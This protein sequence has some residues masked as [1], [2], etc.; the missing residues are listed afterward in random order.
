MRPVTGIDFPVLTHCA[1]ESKE[2]AMGYDM[3]GIGGMMRKD[4]QDAERERKA[5]EKR[6]NPKPKSS[7]WGKTMRKEAYNLAND[8]DKE[9]KKLFGV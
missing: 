3:D 7:G 4:R 2:T 9:L 5:W 1:E 6:F 8:F